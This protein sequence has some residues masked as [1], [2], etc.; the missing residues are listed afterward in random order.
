LRIRDLLDADAAG[1]APL[2]GDLGYAVEPDRI[3]ARLKAIRVA[4][5]AAYVAVDERED[6]LGVIVLA[7]HPV[8]HAAGPVGL[9]TA[10]VVSRSA[11]GKGVGRALVDQ[12]KSWAKGRGCV[13][14]IVTSGEQRADAHA[15]YPA[16]GLA[17]T[18]R[19]FGVSI[20]PSPI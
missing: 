6:P 18:G 8:L 14:L 12:A 10:L 19:R 17:Y 16:C 20:D 11:R 13:R 1:V 5:G 4:Q 2:L 9:I 7:A 3:P 15:F